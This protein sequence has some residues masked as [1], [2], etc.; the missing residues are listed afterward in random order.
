VSGSPEDDD[1]SSYQTHSALGFYAQARLALTGEDSERALLLTR[2]AQMADPNTPY[3]IFLEAEILLKSGRIQDALTAID[4]AIKVAPDY[5]PPYLL[6]GNIMSSMGKTKEAAAYLRHAVRLEPGKED[7]ALHLVTTLMQLFE[8]GESVSVLK[9]LITEKPDSA[10]GNY[11]LGKVYSQMKLYRESVKYYQR[12]LELRPEFI[13]ASID[14]AISH[15]ALGE[16]DQAIAAYKGVLDDAENRAPLIQHLIQLFIQN[17]K[18]EDALVYLKKLDQMG[19]ATVETNRKIGLIYLELERYD[20]AI[21][22]FSEQLKTDPEAHQMRLYLASAYEEKGELDLAVTEFQKIPVNAQVYP[23]AVSHLAF[24]LKEQDKGDE[25][26]ALLEKAIAA[27]QDKL[28][29]YLSLATLQESL[30]HPEKGLTLLLGVESRFSQES[31]F[32]FRVGVLYDKLGKRPQSIERMKKVV[33][34]D[35]KDAQAHNFLGYTYAEMGINLKDALSHVKRA[36]EIRPD[37]AF[38]IDSLGWV[39]YQMKQYEDA[40][41]Y[42]EK[43]AE[44]VTDDPT[45]LE[46]LGDAYSANKQN[47]QALKYYKKA[48]VL[49]PGKKELD[50]KIRHIIRGE[51]DEK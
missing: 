7:A 41:R 35:P 14:M 18:Y 26:V 6:G 38:F 4:R 43:A 9:T 50:D 32:Q 48:K 47:K 34:L 15:E 42:L 45:I 39:Y 51:L 1:L 29:L 8:Y 36:L 31:R 33:E 10:V 17:R 5:R 22:I 44:L 46:H 37:D 11:Y 28:E 12:A 49:D 27:N 30:G 13:Q 2:Q 23:E 20:D 24:I 3:P 19:L 16:Y 25:A 40:V 21:S